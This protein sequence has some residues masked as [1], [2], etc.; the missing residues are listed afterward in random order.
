VRSTLWRVELDVNV[1]IKKCYYIPRVP[2]AGGLSL[3]LAR[4]CG[5][6]IAARLPEGSGSR[7]GHIQETLKDVL[8]RM[9]LVHTAH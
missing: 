4:R 3:W 8:I 1:D 7:Q 6:L 9:L 5:T 2:R